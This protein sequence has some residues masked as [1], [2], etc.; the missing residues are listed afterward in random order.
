MK[1]I[2]NYPVLTLC[3]LAALSLGLSTQA[4][5]KTQINAL[6]MTQAAYSESDIRAMTADFTKQHPDIDVNLEFVPY[7]ALHD[8]IVAARGAG[9]NGYDVVLFDAI[10]PAEFEKY[11]LL[12]DVSSR[13]TG[14]ESKKI[15]DGAMSTVT[16][17]DKRWGMPWILD[18]KYLY[19]NKAMLAKAGITT[20]PATWA[21]VEKQSEILK[22][23]G[24]V[25]YRSEE[26]TSE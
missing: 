2:S 8:K 5:A 25:K 11:G 3:A 4:L 23:K 18:T 16:Y 7:E 26:H 1:I 6:F 22:E 12:Q 9:T 13:I 17:K 19:Y 15:F 24:I 14:D 21:D 10:W 20:P